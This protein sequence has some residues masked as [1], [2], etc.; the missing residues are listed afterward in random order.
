MKIYY[1]DTGVQLGN[2][3]YICLQVFKDRKEGKES[4]VLRGGCFRQAITMFPLLGD[5]FQK[6]LGGEVVLTPKSYYQISGQDYSSQDLDEFCQEVLIPGIEEKIEHIE[7][8][9]I[10]ICIR[11]TDMYAHHQ[12]NDYGFDNLTYVNEALKNYD[13]THSIRVVSDDIDWC[14]NN[15]N[16]AGYADVEYCE[17]DRVNNFWQMLRANKHLIV[18][19]LTFAYWAGY[20]LRV[21][22]KNVLVTVPDFNTY[23]IEDGRQIADT[24]GWEIIPVKT[25]MEK[26]EIGVLYVVTGEYKV[27]FEDFYETARRHLFRKNKVTYYLYTD[28]KEYFEKYKNREDIK[29]TLVEHKPFPYP[30]LY[31]YHFF[32]KNQDI[33]KNEDVILFFNANTIFKEDI[34]SKLLPSNTDKLKLMQY[35]GK[36][37]KTY[38][39]LSFEK[40]EESRAYI[41]YVEGVVYTYVQGGFLSAYSNFFQEI[42]SYFIES[43]DAD[44]M[45]GI[46]PVW[47]DESYLNKFVYERKSET[48]LLEYDIYSPEQYPVDSPIILLDKT[49]KGGYQFLRFG[50]KSIEN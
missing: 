45:N 44:Q 30:T 35:P 20:I 50:N 42:V 25:E 38:N 28:E 32:R 13:K 31:R 39:V 19:N 46:T 21:L 1:N 43:T 15:L 40:R 9:D 11:R 6:A 24:R 27:F 10:V 37:V 29:I 22:D 16:I 7:K 12:I 8:K 48:E 3:L 4:G 49:Q 47:H 18:P 34:S 41:P 26:L 14:K 36:R 2:L 33:W 5:Y 17:T 23:L